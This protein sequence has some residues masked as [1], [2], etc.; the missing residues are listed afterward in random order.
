MARGYSNPTVI[1][2]S[3]G[4]G[5]LVDESVTR[6]KI[7]NLA[8]DATKLADDAVTSSKIADN[9]VSAAHITDDAVTTDTIADNAV[10]NS[11]IADNAITHSN[12]INGS[13]AST[14]LADN[15]VTTSK[16]PDGA[17]TWPKLAGLIPASKLGNASV[18][19]MQLANGAVTTAKIGN[20]QVTGSKL[21]LNSVYPSNLVDGSVQTSKIWNGAVTTDKIADGA[22]TADKIAAGTIASI[23]LGAHVCIVGRD[24]FSSGIGISTP[25]PIPWTDAEHDTSG[26]W[27]TPDV[28][29]IPEDGYYLFAGNGLVGGDEET[30]EDGPYRFV[31]LQVNAVNYTANRYK[32]GGVGFGR[33]SMNQCHYLEAGDVVK[34][35][36][37]T[38][39]SMDRIGPCRL[40]ITRVPGG[41]AP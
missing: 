31:Y 8:V 39:G 16:I 1:A 34:L 33:W 40:A 17:V 24:G 41:T 12:I 30:G 9:A 18:G 32:V 2:N 11:K 23:S 7:A 6:P 25:T 5:A 15:A 38:T 27:E 36:C 21:A 29:E 20:G 22:V 14:K 28:F 26:M 10:T 19:E 3:V 37:E 4:T 13:I 35:M